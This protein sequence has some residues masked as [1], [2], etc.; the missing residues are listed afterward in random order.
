M[1][2][3]RGGGSGN[4]PRLK[5][6]SDVASGVL[7]QEAACVPPVEGQ[8]GKSDSHM[9]GVIWLCAISFFRDPVY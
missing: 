2:A 1:Y 6:W 3:S 9:R 5:E 8:Q 7:R 4:Q